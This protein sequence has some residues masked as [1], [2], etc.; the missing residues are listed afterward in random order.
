VSRSA[1]SRIALPEKS[2][3]VVFF[4]DADNRSDVGKENDA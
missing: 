3:L 2:F 4:S 1:D